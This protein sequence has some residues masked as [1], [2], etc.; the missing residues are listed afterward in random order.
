M[1]RDLAKKKSFVYLLEFLF[2]T[3]IIY[4]VM[5]SFIPIVQKKVEYEIIKYSTE[6]VIDAIVN[7]IN[8]VTN[9]DEDVLI[10]L[11]SNVEAR[12]ELQEKL[13]IFHTKRITYILILYPDPI[14]DKFRYIMDVWGG[15]AKL[16]DPFS[17]INTEEIE[18]LQKVTKTGKPAYLKH[19]D[20]DIIGITYYFPYTQRGLTKLII[21]IDFSFET[22][23]E[24]ENI[25]TAV[26]YIILALIVFQGS[27]IAIL[28]FS[29]FRNLLLRQKAF[30]DNLTKV[31]NRNYL[32]SIKDIINLKNYTVVMTDIDHFKKINDTYG[33]DKGDIVLA[34]FAQTLVNNL[35]KN[36]I[37]VR[38]GGEEFLILLDTPRKNKEAIYNILERIRRR[39]SQDK[40][41]DNI[42]YTAS[43][44]VFL[45]TDKVSSLDDAI[46][47]ADLALYRA[48]KL[49]RDKVIIYDSSMDELD[50]S[51]VDIKRIIDE[52]DII[53]YYQPIINLKE[54][55][56]FYYEALARLKYGDKI[57]PPLP[58]ID[59]I[60]GS[61]YY[62]K[63]TKIVL[64]FNIEIL[65]KYPKIKIGVNLSTS[66]F[67]NTKLIERLESLDE[68]FIKRL[69]L[70]ITGGNDLRDY[71][72][73]KENIEKLLKRG[74]TLILDDFGKGNTD[75][76]LLTQIDVKYIKIDGEI[77][78]RI[79]KDERYYKI[80]KYITMFCKD[81]N[82]KTIAE[83]IEN[84]EIYQK[85][86]EAGVEYG[87]GY[88]FSKPLPIDAIYRDLDL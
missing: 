84:E 70:E 58:Y 61:D 65:K 75:F 18:V 3:S 43:F 54:K 52:R 35:R 33:H 87:Q 17:P 1:M 11:L 68:T 24:I 49:G 48:K 31:Y 37:V 14:R 86:M 53:C 82:K 20:T 42:K 57:L 13:K 83:Y 78:K 10:E 81:I 63:F 72:P 36:D 62:A 9:K 29:I 25:A 50:L 22:L 12:R 71:E 47:K 66:D 56:V 40:P 7:A 79:S 88:Y 73:L 8:S 5:Y 55:N 23:K 44:G 76:E 60:K 15:S 69:Y 28:F 30:T 19:S 16:K 6:N 80:L 59:L 85:V 77:I 4:G 32:D 46:K 21:A 74:Y 34:H 26:K 67:L 41:I 27:V 39:V 45:D 2:I 38:Y 51:I 64:D